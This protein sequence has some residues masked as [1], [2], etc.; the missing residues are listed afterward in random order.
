MAYLEIFLSA[1]TGRLSDAGLDAVPEYESGMKPVPEDS[2]FVT[3]AVT[4]VRHEPPLPF[5]GG[6][7]LPVTL[8]LRLRFHC[9]TGG[10]AERLSVC[11][12]LTVLPALLRMG[13]AVSAAEFGGTVYDRTLDRLVREG[14]VRIAGAV[15]LTPLQTA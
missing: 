3:A 11:W 4:D 10:D 6:T 14:T 7:A 15:T 13:L 9:R 12:E 8:T 5:D 2:F 1:V